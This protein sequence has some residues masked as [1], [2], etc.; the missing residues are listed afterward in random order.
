M[1]VMFNG[2]TISANAQRTVD[3]RDSK[4]QRVAHATMSPSP[5]RESSQME[6]ANLKLSHSVRQLAHLA[7]LTP[8]TIFHLCRDFNFFVLLGLTFWKGGPLLTN[9]LQARSRSIQRA[10]EE[11]QRF[12]EEAALRL[13]D[14][15]KRWAQLDSAIAAIRAL[16]EV[17]VKHEEQVLGARTTEDIRR[18]GEFSQ[19]EIDSAAQR[20][21]HELKAFAG[22]LAVSLA[23]AS[24]QINK[25]TDEELVK[26]F[27]EGLGHQEFAQTTVQHPAQAVAN[28]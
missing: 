26:S 12:A 1:L 24:I 18:L 6:Y 19:S 17:E 7:G 25:R 14:V 13:A 16:A 23:R 10:I 2:I 28:L 27:I 8:N 20:A 21:R 22:G 11:A 4:A 3:T 15:E 5:S 9:A